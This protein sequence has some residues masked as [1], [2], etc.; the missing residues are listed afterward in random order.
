MIKCKNC[1]GNLVYSSGKY[2]C[3]SCSSNFSIENYYEDVD[4]YI[5]CIENDEAGRRT[6][7][8]IIAQDI[9]QRL[10][11]N[12]IKTFYSRISADGLV[13]E[14][15][16]QVCNTAMHFAKTLIVLGT[17][18][19]Y[20]NK[21]LELHKQ[22]FDSK[23]VI[24]VY[25][26]MDAYAIPKSISSIQALNYNKVGSTID[27][28]SSIL[29]ALGREKE[30]DFIDLSQK[31]SSRKKKTIIIVSSVII[32]VIAILFLVVGGNFIKQKNPE[33]AT[34]DTRSDAYK[35]A[36][37]SYENGNYVDAIKIFTELSD[38]NDSEKQLLTTYQKYAG[39]YADGEKITL[40]LQFWDGNSVGIEIKKSIGGKQ[41]T[42]S[43]TTTLNG[44]F[45]ECGFNDSENNQGN[46]ILT[47]TNKGVKLSVKTTTKN[48]DVG[49]GDFD[50]S[51]LLTQK[52]DKPFGTTLDRETLLSFVKGKTT[53]NDLK[54]AGFEV[55]L[56][57]QLDRSA[58]SNA[59]RIKNTDI[60]LAVYN[61]DVSQYT[62]SS[63]SFENFQLNE[64]A[65][66]AISAP[67]SVIISDKIGEVIDPYVDDNILYVPDGEI[68]TYYGKVGFDS[69]YP[70][71]ASDIKDDTVVGFTSKNILGETN[72]NELSL[73]FFSRY[74]LLNA[75]EEYI[76]LNSVDVDFVPS[77]VVAENETSYLIS[78][79]D[80]GYPLDYFVADKI[81]NEVEYIATLDYTDYFDDPPEIW[82]DYPEYFSDFID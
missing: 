79:V 42:I 63:E 49:M 72:F 20:F 34:E 55:V 57:R 81:T 77:N 62:N 38:Y 6:R 25:A 54:R 47:F 10:E 37:T 74:A 53:L 43:E 68:T 46:F 11:N 80:D 29:N 14:D 61:Y 59:Y 66:F 19:Q 52:S 24:P 82:K 58:N 17:Q 67:A 48:S 75:R 7:D 64:P 60:F 40:H 50:T 1:G 32:V 3:E 27:L 78:V 33:K 71:K 23:I 21:L 69:P 16:E 35:S 65:V 4:T 76:K 8:S 26:D 56:E 41:C 2:V 73:E 51:F 70:P 13:D 28:T 9:Y 44:D 39:Y 36:I 45:A 31:A 12:K 30:I 22:Y 5:C 15:F 18:P